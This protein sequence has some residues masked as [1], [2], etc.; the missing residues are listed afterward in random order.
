M[1]KLYWIIGAGIL[2]TQ[3]AF[4]QPGEGQV[5]LQ[6]LSAPAPHYLPEYT[7]DV[8]VD[9][10]SWIKQQPGLHV[11]FG[12]TDE[13]Y[14]RCEVPAVNQESLTWEGT[15]WRGERL[16][17]Q[18][19]VWSPDTIE[20]IRIRVSDLLSAEGNKISVDNI[21]LNMVRYVLSDY[22]YGA[23]NFGCDTPPEGAWLMPDRLEAFERFNLPEKTVRPVWIALEIPRTAEPGKYNG[24]IEINSIQSKV[25]LKV[26]ITVQKQILPE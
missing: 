14:L 17:T 9:T 19:L 20:Q 3:A 23:T 26:T 5:Q 6:K 25:T 2:L 7:Y 15:G 8:T 11:A 4:A 13:L 1:N 22:P 12:S 18:V 16:N 21:K 24:T 10:M